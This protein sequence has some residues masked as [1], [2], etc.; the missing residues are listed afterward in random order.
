MKIRTLA[1][2]SLAVMSMSSFAQTGVER[3]FEMSAAANIP[4]YVAHGINVYNGKPIGDYSAVAPKTMMFSANPPIYEI[5]VL[6]KGQ[7]DSGEI[8][9][10]TDRSRLVATTRSFLNAMNPTGE[11]NPSW[12]NVPLGDIGTTFF[13]STSITDRV[14]PTAYPRKPIDPVIYRMKGVKAN[15]TV[16]DWEKISGRLTYLNL[17]DGTSMVRVTVR[18]GFPN[19]VYTLWDVGVNNPQ[20]DKEAAYAVPFGGLPNIV[21]TDGKGCGFKEIKLPYQL[22]RECKPGATSCTSYISLFYHW[23]GQVFGGSPAATWYGAPVGVI[24]GN[25]MVWPTTGRVLT[26]PATNFGNKPHGCNS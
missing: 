16:G 5:G 12:I 23:D 4:G 26:K 9:E 25:Q 19:A 2:A 8:T 10:A 22:N 15:P 1:L 17:P 14:T 6:Q 24:A 18:E 21:Q 11:V 3:V 20:T 13:G 7:T